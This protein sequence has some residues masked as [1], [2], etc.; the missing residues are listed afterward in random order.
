MPRNER[1]PFLTVQDVWK[2]YPAR[3]SPRRWKQ[4]GVPILRGV[5]LALEKGEI[6]GL[7]GESGSGKSTL[8]RLVLGLE[9][10]DAGRILVE[11]VPVRQWRKTHRGKISVVFQDA[12]TSVNPRFTVGE[13]IAEGFGAA[14]NPA[15]PAA[16]FAMMERVELSPELAACFPHQL[17]GGQVQRVCIA[18]ALA[19]Q[20]DV[21]VFDEAVSALDVPV[22]AEI[23]RL[24]KS[25]RGTAAYLFI[26]HDIQ[27]AAMLCDRI[28][29][30]HHGR[31]TD[32]LRMQE[33]K[34][35]ASPY[36]QRLLASTLLFRSSFESDLHDAMLFKGKT[37]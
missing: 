25:I 9:L 11:G 15:D 5:S 12:A 29:F 23:V 32:D 20:P 37:L 24:L 16:V 13:I 4:D 31:I 10:P 34:H 2:S 36:L 28:A 14:S 1:V 35:G 7:L 6:L 33:M 30:L 19:S 17:S 27:V 3:R 21:I 26:T 18:R 8:S 22:Q